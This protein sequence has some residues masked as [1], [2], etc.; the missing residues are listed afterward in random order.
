[1]EVSKEGA[2]ANELWQRTGARMTMS[3][4]EDIHE[5]F[6]GAARPRLL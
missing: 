2:T 4:E 5:T 3:I 1:M 6:I